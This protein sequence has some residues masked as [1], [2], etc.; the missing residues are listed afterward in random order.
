MVGRVGEPKGSPFLLRSSNPARSTTLVV[1]EA[2]VAGIQPVPQESTMAYTTTHKPGKRSHKRTTL[3]RSPPQDAAL[4][5][6]DMRQ[7]LTDG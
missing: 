3:Q 2:W 1:S 4:M 6:E 7:L 5:Q